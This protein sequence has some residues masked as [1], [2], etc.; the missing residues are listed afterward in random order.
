LVGPSDSGGWLHYFTG[1]DISTPFWEFSD[2]KTLL[3]LEYYLDLKKDLKD[4]EAI[5]YFLENNYLYYFAGSRP[6]REG[7]ATNEELE[8]HGWDI[9]KSIGAARLYR[10]PKCD[11]SNL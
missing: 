11:P 2:K 1:N 6:A 7:L 8:K 9:V 4:C 3:N 5:N 10:I